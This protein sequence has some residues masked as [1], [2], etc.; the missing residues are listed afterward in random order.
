MASHCLPHH[1]HTHL[2]TTL[3]SRGVGMREGP[4]PVTSKGLGII[5][6]R[7]RERGETYRLESEP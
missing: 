4:Q 3:A 2:K 7:R 5:W 1:T 6:P